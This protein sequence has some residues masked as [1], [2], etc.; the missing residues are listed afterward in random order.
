[1]E[2][3]E[4]KVKGNLTSARVLGDYVNAVNRDGYPLDEEKISEFIRHY[5]LT[6][7]QQ[8]TVLRACKNFCI[9]VKDIR[10]QP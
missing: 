10:K 2:N 7:D 6:E 1:M 5:D 8:K 3:I 9:I 4:T